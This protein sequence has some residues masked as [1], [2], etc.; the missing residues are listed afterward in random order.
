MYYALLHVSGK[1]VEFRNK[2]ELNCWIEQHLFVL[3]R[4]TTLK[5]FLYRTKK[6]ET[7]LNRELSTCICS[8]HFYMSKNKL[9][10]DGK[11]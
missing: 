4:Q 6:F 7:L 2:S 10:Q 11:N 8:L 1:C 5:W 3:N 9:F